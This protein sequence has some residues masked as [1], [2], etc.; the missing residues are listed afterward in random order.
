MK[1]LQAL[2]L[3]VR[4]LDRNGDE[5]ELKDDEDEGFTPDRRQM[6]DFDYASDEGEFAAARLHH[7][8]DGSGRQRGL[9]FRGRRAVH[10]RFRRYGIR[11]Q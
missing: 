6:S 1:E 5:V 7:R 10:R 2:C 9:R 4:V 11:T 8:Q 3:D